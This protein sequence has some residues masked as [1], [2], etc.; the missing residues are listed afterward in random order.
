M[1]TGGIPPPKKRYSWNICNC[2]NPYP[3]PL[4]IFYQVFVIVILLWVPP[5]RI[6]DWWWW[7]SLSRCLLLTGAG[8][9]L[10][11]LP[12]THPLPTADR[13]G[14]RGAPSHPQRLVQCTGTS[15]EKL[16]H[17]VCGGY[18]KGKRNIT[19]IYTAS[20]YFINSLYLNVHGSASIW[21]FIGDFIFDFKWFNFTGFFS[22]FTGCMCTAFLKTTALHL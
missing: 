4:K 2:Q 20:M 7:A 9:A 16:C 8:A 11:P 18:Q 17:Q 1:W 14:P 15:Q 19:C 13:A 12:P 3:I 21:Y 22:Y 6:V 5:P 10:G